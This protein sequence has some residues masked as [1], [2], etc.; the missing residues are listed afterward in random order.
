MAD[1]SWTE[2]ADGWQEEAEGTDANGPYTSTWTLDTAFNV[3]AYAYADSTDLS[4][5]VTASGFNALYEATDYWEGWSQDGQL[6]WEES[7]HLDFDALGRPAE[8]AHDYAQYSRGRLTGSLSRTASFSY[9][10]P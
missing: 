9:D 5:E 3:L 7:I 2:T 1:L 8:E 6:F 4:V 10:C